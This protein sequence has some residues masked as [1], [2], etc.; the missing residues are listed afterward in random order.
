MVT[1]RTS[2]RCVT[3][4]ILPVKAVV[5]HAECHRKQMYDH[6][7]ITLEMDKCITLIWFLIYWLCE[8]TFYGAFWN[9]S[10]SFVALWYTLRCKSNSL[11]DHADQIGMVRSMGGLVLVSVCRINWTTNRLKK[12][13]YRYQ[14][15]NHKCLTIEKSPSMLLTILIEEFWMN[16]ICH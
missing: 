15:Y 8:S 4:L 10:T 5:L 3:G 13:H 6:E 1:S 2:I 12:Q 7:P 14:K 16:A 9:P 11:C